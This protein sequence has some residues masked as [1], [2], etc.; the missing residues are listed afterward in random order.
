MSQVLRIIPE[1]RTGN[2]RRRVFSLHRFFY[3]GSERR[4]AIH[5]RRA[6]EERRDGWIRISKWS[7]TKLHDLKISRY[8]H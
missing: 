1:R 6:K 3:K 2:D 7:S 8:L 4:K 5:D